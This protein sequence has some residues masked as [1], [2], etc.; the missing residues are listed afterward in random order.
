MTFNFKKDH[1]GIK[2]G[3]DTVFLSK[4]QRIL[5]TTRYLKLTSCFLT[6]CF[7]FILIFVLVLSSYST[8][9][10]SVL[11]YKHAG[12]HSFYCGSNKIQLFEFY[13]FLFLIFFC[14]C[15]H[16]YFNFFLLVLLPLFLG[17]MTIGLLHTRYLRGI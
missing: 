13:F 17:R 8:L 11:E 6:S 9:L 1:L 2:G 5:D 7:W 3:P 10:V 16:A 14:F 15:F 4:H 12:I